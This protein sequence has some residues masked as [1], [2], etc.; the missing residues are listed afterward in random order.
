[1]KIPADKKDQISLLG[2]LLQIAYL[3]IFSIINFS[4]FYLGVIIVGLA[5]SYTKAKNLVLWV[6]SFKKT[7]SVLIIFLV[8]CVALYLAFSYSFDRVPYSYDG[9]LQYIRTVLSL[10]NDFSYK[11]L[12]EPYKPYLVELLWAVIWD[13]GNYN[14][15][16]L[17]FGVFTLLSVYLA[18]SFYRRLN[19]NRETITLALLILVSCPFFIK[20][21]FVEFKVEPFLLTCSMISLIL[22]LKCFDRKNILSFLMLGM[23]LGVTTLVKIIILPFPLLLIFFIFLHYFLSKLPPKDYIYPSVALVAFVATIAVWA[24]LFGMKINWTTIKLNPL[25]QTPPIT[26]T[27][28]PNVY[29]ACVN[30]IQKTDTNTYYFNRDIKDLVLQPINALTGNFPND[31][32]LSFMDPG[33]I[34]YLSV[35]TFF[36]VFLFKIPDIRL[37]Y[38]L[39][40][41]QIFI[42]FFI[43]RIQTIYW[44]LYFLAPIISLSIP[45]QLQA[46]PGKY[47]K[48]LRTVVISVAVGQLCL[49]LLATAYRIHSNGYRFYN[50]LKAFSSKIDN[51]PKNLYIL[52]ASIDVDHVLMPFVKNYDERVVKSNYYFASSGKSLET[53]KDEL[54]R[55]NIG[56]LITYEGDKDAISPIHGCPEKELKKVNEFVSLYGVR[57][58]GIQDY[59]GIYAIKD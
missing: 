22:Y 2:V 6:L 28:N 51:L 14:F 47:S 17:S 57:L 10:K 37:K 36:L 54:V 3:I 58:G 53:I 32:R 45:L 48:I 23:M 30:E 39:I 52:D 1:M 43:F 25:N 44:Y 12:E 7:K 41:T 8:V 40:A 20:Y 56:Y 4:G 29:E 19:L 26:L 42:I 49:T 15:V 13:F 35:W 21:A 33:I 5:F 46:L 27:R 31:I 59:A 38:L 24:V 11:M 50:T 18:Y 34:I 16:M 55:N 9:M